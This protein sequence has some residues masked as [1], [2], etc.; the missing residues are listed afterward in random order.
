[1]AE[2]V[3]LSTMCREVP[4]APIDPNAT[5]NGLMRK[6]VGASR[7][8]AAFSRVC[9]IWNVEAAHSTIEGRDNA[10][11]WM[12]ENSQA[13]EEIRVLLVARRKAE[14]AKL[15]APPAESAAA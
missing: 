4:Q 2:G 1:V 8:P 5:P 12:L 15:G 13:A 11:K 9:G 7:E 3:Y 10:C 6:L 14:N